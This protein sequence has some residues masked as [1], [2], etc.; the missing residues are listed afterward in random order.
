MW[1]WERVEQAEARPSARRS[2]VLG[3]LPGDANEML[4]C[5]GYN[6]DV[7]GDAWRLTLDVSAAPARKSRA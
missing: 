4:L 7:L 1:C 6:G 5:D 2:H 3:A